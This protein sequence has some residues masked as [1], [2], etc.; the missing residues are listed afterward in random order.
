MNNSYLYL[1]NQKIQ[2]PLMILTIKNI[3]SLLNMK[4][5]YK[6]L[7]IFAIMLLSNSCGDDTI[8]NNNSNEVPVIDSNIFSWSYIPVPGRNFFDSYVADTNA[9]FYIL[10][11]NVFY[12]NGN[13]SNQIYSVFTDGDALSLD[14]V[15]PDLIFIGG[16]NSE[17]SNYKPWLK[18]WNGSGFE[19]IVLP[20][21]SNDQVNEVCV[22]TENSVWFAGISGR[23]YHYNGIS[24]SSYFINLPNTYPILFL[25]DNQIYFYTESLANYGLR[26]VYRFNYNDWELV[27]ADTSNFGLNFS[28]RR[29]FTFGNYALRKTPR[30]LEEFN[31]NS[32]SQF[33]NT[34]VFE[35]YSVNGNNL[36]DF[37]CIGI[38]DGTLEF[39]PY[40]YNGSKWFKQDRAI[41]EN[42]F[43]GFPVELKYCKGTYFGFYYA[44]ASI[45]H[46]YIS[47]G[48]MNTPPGK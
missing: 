25:K 40:Y 42:I 31:S 14:G 11:G 13:T 41:P 4:Y 27:V 2:F 18:K 21:D 32:W 47:V 43:Y 15:S 6:L 34:P 29:L 38:P 1:S 28:S 45:S 46:N 20:L 35:A 37:V 8:T 23:I 24:V 9:I 26:Y 10:D 48:K 36:S 12:Y 16:Y 7:P 33:L 17:N 39:F 22:E 3:C 44:L 5:L 19:E 30:Y